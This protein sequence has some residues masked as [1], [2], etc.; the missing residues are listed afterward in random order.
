MQAIFKREFRSYFQTM[1]GPVFIAIMLSFVGVY[2]MSINLFQGY[3]YFSGTLSNLIFLLLISIPILSMK[4]FAE[5]RRSKSEQL[6]LSAPV[7]LWEITL[8]KYFAM[9]CVYAIPC[10]VCCFYPLVIKMVGHCNLRN[11]YAGILIYFLIGCAFIAVGMFISSLTES[12]IIAVVASF[13]VLFLFYI[14]DSLTN[15]LP[16]SA[17]GSLIGLIVFAAV[18]CGLYYLMAKN[19]FLSWIFFIIITVILLVIF[20]IKSSLFSNALAHI[21]GTFSI[22]SGMDNINSYHLLDLTAV[23]KYISIAFFFVFLTVQ[24]LNKRRWS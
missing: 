24:G 13:G 9:V 19:A 3:P 17:K 15:Y 16:T 10:L 21:M 1:I 4:S 8:G 6:F 18:L 23:F 2:F 22:Y 7:S 5:E 14:W 11:D 12:Q 20:F